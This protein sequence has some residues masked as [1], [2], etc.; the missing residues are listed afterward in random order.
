MRQLVSRVQRE[1]TLTLG[2]RFVISPREVK[3]R[4]ESRLNERRER[5]ER[6]RV[7]DLGKR[8]RRAA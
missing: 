7:L 6:A 1:H 5:L 8:V 2:N 4:G 3:H